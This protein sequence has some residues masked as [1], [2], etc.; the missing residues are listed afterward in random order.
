M[1]EF[2][3]VWLVVIL[4][5]VAVICTVVDLWLLMSSKQKSDQTQPAQEKENNRNAV[6]RALADSTETKIYNLII[7]D[8]SGS[9]DCIRQQAMDS[10]NETIQTIRAA[11]ERNENQEHFVTLVTFNDT[12]TIVNDCAPINE[13]KELTAE[14]YRPDC[15]TALYDA[16][17]IS[18]SA[19]RKKVS[20]EDKVLVTIVTDGYENASQEYNLLT[21]KALVEEL[22]AKGWMF[23][24][25]GA[26]QD[27]EEVAFSMS[28]DNA[29]SW[30]STIEGTDRMSKRLNYSRSRWYDEAATNSERIKGFFDE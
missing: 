28:I 1:K 3:N 17:G 6:H 22:K 11:Q 14:S 13:I 15:C 30:E 7:I 19:L 5:V 16:M 12:A 21:I 24:Y 4:L 26:N 18:L 27:A 25:L 9:M 29:M 23:A 2:S 10:V 8:E 20:K